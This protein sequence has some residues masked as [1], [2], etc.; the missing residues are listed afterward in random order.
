MRKKYDAYLKEIPQEALPRVFRDTFRLAGQAGI[1]YVWI[2]SLCIVQ[3]SSDHGDWIREAATMGSVYRHSFCNVA[4]TGFRN[5]DNGLFVSR[6][7]D[8]L[9][10]IGVELKENVHLDVSRLCINGGGD[11][12][13]AG[14][15]LL[16]DL[17]T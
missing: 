7:P 9:Q 15:Y 1:N 16:I 11:D 8:L 4:A 2:D 14:Q 3:D 10:P 17:D 6:E 12:L 13:L 5:G